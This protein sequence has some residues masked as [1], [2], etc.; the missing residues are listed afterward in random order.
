MDVKIIELFQRS[1]TRKSPKGWLLRRASWFCGQALDV[2]LIRLVSKCEFCA[3]LFLD[4]LP[5]KYVPS[6]LF[7]HIWKIAY[8]QVEVCTI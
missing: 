3:D 2:Y 4:N 6:T 7:Y 1:L 5:P 8:I